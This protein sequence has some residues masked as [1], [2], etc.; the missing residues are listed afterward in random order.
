MNQFT[1]RVTRP[2]DKMHKPFESTWIRAENQSEA[3]SILARTYKPKLGFKLMLAQDLKGDQMKA[4]MVRFSKQ[5]LDS[6]Q[7]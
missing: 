6:A 2:G 7:L 5:S 4:Q 1:F 3:K